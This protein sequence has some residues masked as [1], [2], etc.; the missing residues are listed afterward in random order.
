M[1]DLSSLVVATSD[2]EMPRTVDRLLSRGFRY[3]F[4][5]LKR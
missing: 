2:L 4:F 5:L 3:S 1:D